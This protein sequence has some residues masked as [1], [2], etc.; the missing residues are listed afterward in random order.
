MSEPHINA[1]QRENVGTAHSRRIRR[2]GEIPCVL[3]GTEQETKD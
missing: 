1:N 2:N 3:Y